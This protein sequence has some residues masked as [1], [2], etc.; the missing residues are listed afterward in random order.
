VRRAI[1]ESNL[2]LVSES[3]AAIDA[4]L[5]SLVYHRRE[6]ESYLPYHPEC[7]YSL[8]P[9]CVGEEAP[10]V[11]K[12]AARATEVVGVGPM[13]AIPGALA[14]LSLGRMLCEGAEVNLVENGGEIAMASKQPLCVGIYAGRSPLS[15]KI[16]FYLR[17][18]DFPLSV[19]TSS[20][21]VSHALN[22]GEADA[23]VVVADTASLADA[24]AT[25]VSNA[26]RGGD[27]EASIQA[28]L[29]VAGSLPGV[30]A[31]LII[32]GRYVGSVGR[33]PQ[34]VRLGGGV[35][36]MLRAGLHDLAP[37]RL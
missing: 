8:E 19:A 33:L 15:G 5:E 2:L 10:L 32:R 14:E 12:L 13:A 20:A 3:T 37:I 21:T 30:R 31:S 18:E 29:E 25:A 7:Q 4:G 9:V 22:F 36:E 17:P 26:V 1:K 24:A 28:G 16:G 11:V 34:L 35:D 6:L 23:A 27:V